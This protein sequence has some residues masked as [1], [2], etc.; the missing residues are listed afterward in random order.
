M[1]KRYYILSLCALYLLSTSASGLHAINQAN[2][3]A[4][5]TTQAEEANTQEAENTQPTLGNSWKKLVLFRWGSLSRDDLENI[6]LSVFCVAG[7]YGVYYLHTHNFDTYH[8]QVPPHTPNNPT[9]PTI[10]PAPAVAG[11][12]PTHQEQILQNLLDRAEQYT[13]GQEVPTWLTQAIQQVLDGEVT[14]DNSI[15]SGYDKTSSSETSSEEESSYEDIITAAPQPDTNTSSVTPTVEPQ[16]VIECPIC[17]DDIE[18]QDQKK[19]SCGHTY[20]AD[21][22]MGAINTGIKDQN[23]ASMKCPDPNCNHQFD[24]QE[25]R[26]ITNNNKTILGQYSTITLTEFF[27]KQAG[28][29]IIRQCPT[30]DCSYAFINDRNDTQSY[31]CPTCKHTYCANCLVSH[32]RSVSCKEAQETQDPSKNEAA[33]EKW[34][35]ENTKPCPHCKKPIQKNDGCKHMTCN[36]G[37]EFCWVC[38]AKW[39]YSHGCPGGDG[40]YGGLNNDLE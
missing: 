23:T 6:A 22:L 16:E 11:T 1:L 15:S 38:L 17:M 28:D 14:H 12:I 40:Y 39:A 35:K 24:E 33:F 20:C 4:T 27:K 37:Y 19:L 7:I 21:C 29:K 3:S 2:V 32:S 8:N 13:N 18:P 30:P 10:T 5:Q 9:H 26:N 25:I 34:V 31:T 36:C